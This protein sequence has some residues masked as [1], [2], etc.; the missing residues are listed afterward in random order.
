M[1][2]IS[3]LRQLG[4]TKIFTFLEYNRRLMNKLVKYSVFAWD[5]LLLY[6]YKEELEQMLKLFVEV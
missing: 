3:Y 2:K 1:R 4:M 5:L 6:F